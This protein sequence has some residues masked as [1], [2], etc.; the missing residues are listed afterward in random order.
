MDPIIDSGKNLSFYRHIG[1]LCPRWLVNLK[2]K[3]TTS[4][5]NWNS[6]GQLLYYLILSLWM[7]GVL[8]L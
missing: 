5:W 3:I 4:Q 2:N 8:Q 1:G 6:A 7:D